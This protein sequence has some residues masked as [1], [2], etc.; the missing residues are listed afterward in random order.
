MKS[1]FIRNLLITLISFFYTAS[2]L[3]S[4]AVPVPK[5]FEDIFNARQQGIF[6]VLYGDLSLGTFS[7][8]FDRQDALLLSPVALA[9]Q[10]YAA[11]SA[12]L[13]LTQA[14]LLSALSA[15]LKRLSADA[16]SDSDIGVILDEN[17]ATLRVILPANLFHRDR[18]NKEKSYIPYQSSSG[19]IHAHNLNYLADSYGDNVS[20]SASETLNLTGNS[21]LRSAWS[22]ARETDFSLEELALYLEHEN[23]RFKIG[24]QRLSDNFITGTPSASYSFFNPVSFDGVALGYMGDNYLSA[25]TGAA[26]PVT[27]YLPQAGTVEVYRQGRM[28]DIQQFPAGL[29]HLDTGSWPAGGYEVLLVSRLINGARE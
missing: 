22:Y 12:S 1:T 17:N 21:Y 3:A 16:A 27:V 7:V 19:F 10:I 9:E 5:G 6:E 24:R 25:G 4:T 2:L 15:P 26:S 8:D 28:I 20:V 11:D 18:P 14:A 23:Q 13:N 29:Q